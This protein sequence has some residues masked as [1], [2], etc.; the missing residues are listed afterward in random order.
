MKKTVYE[1]YWICRIKEGENPVVECFFHWLLLFTIKKRRS[2]QKKRTVS[3][4]VIVFTVFQLKN[5]KNNK[6]K[7]N[8]NLKQTDFF[9]VKR[10]FTKE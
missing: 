9:L 4:L 8:F 7:K 1:S 5:S 6:K 2:G 10:T 3:V